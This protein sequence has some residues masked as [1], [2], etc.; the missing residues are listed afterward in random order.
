VRKPAGLETLTISEQRGGPP[1]RDID[2]RLY[3]WNAKKVKAAANELQAVLRTLT[4]VSG[5]EDDMPYGQEQWIYTLTPQGMALGLTIESVGRQLRAAFDGQLVQIF[6]EGYDEIE[7]RVYLP[8]NERYNLASLE[9]FTL[10]L[11]QGVSVPF[12]TAVQL[13]TQQGLEA[14]RHGEGRLAV[15]VSADVDE[16]VNNNNRIL[17]DLKQNFLPKL[18]AEYGIEYTFEGRAADQADTLRDMRNGVVVAIVLMYLILALQFGSYGWPLVVMAIIPFGLVGALFGHWVTGIDVT[19]LSLFGFF[20]LSGIVVNDSI[21]LVTFY[22]ELRRDETI[23][24]EEALV[25]AV[26][27]RLRAVLL[28]SLTTIFG[29]LPLLFETSLQAQ[30]LIPMATSIAF[31]LMFSTFLVL[32]AVPALLI[33]YEQAVAVFQ[34]GINAVKSFAKS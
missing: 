30:F 11:P 24:I 18:K 10:Q 12:S 19:L 27:Q 15:Q 21:V 33:V 34:A 3:G 20:G 14:I 32:L 26:C 28:T 8:D 31:G 17:A 16:T 23:S 7:V 1:G 4:G 5:I 29:L 13:K 9:D 6:Q 22:K 25:E 2:I